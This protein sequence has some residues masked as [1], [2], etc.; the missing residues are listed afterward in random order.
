MDVSGSGEE[1]LDELFKTRRPQTIFSLIGKAESL[2][3]ADWLMI[4]GPF[5]YGSQTLEA[6]SHRLAGDGLLGKGPLSWDC[7]LSHL[8]CLYIRCLLW[9]HGVQS[10]LL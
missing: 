1:N 8:C 6:G 3:V 4:P 9:H 5:H 10:G 7:A 2:S